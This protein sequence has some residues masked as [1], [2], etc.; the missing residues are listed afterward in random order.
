MSAPAATT[1]RPASFAELPPGAVIAH[2]GGALQ[3]P[4]H[5]LEGYAV[6]LEQGLWVIEPD[7]QV[8]ADGALGV[9]HDGT[10]D[11]TTTSTGN[12]A[13]RSAATWKDLRLDPRTYL[14][15]GWDDDLRAP[16]FDE[17]LDALAGRVL[18]CPEAKSAGTMEPMLDA[19]ERRGVP[20]ATVLVQ[21]F[22]VAECR[23]AL[24]RGWDA[25]WRGRPRPAR[26]AAEG[27]GWIGP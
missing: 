4:E 11:R 18:L 9:M 6:A 27:V 8:L 15:G 17:V 13:D 20:R 23:A 1:A 2:R 5:T 16:L 24:A 7:V 22:A 26:A 25:V 3:V 21:S 19:L 10:V 12:V 14:G